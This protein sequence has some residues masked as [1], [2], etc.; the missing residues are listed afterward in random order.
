MASR[1]LTAPTRA[2]LRRSRG[3]PLC[4]D[5]CVGQSAHEKHNGSAN[6]GNPFHGFPL[7]KEARHSGAL[8]KL[9]DPFQTCAGGCDAGLRA[10]LPW[11][12]RRDVF[13][14]HG[15]GWPKTVPSGRCFQI[16]IPLLKAE[17]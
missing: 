15:G 7:G 11:S 5:G 2:W 6:D 8:E 14:D 10:V 16:L 12:L 1:K 3:F 17:P 13:L 9:P 4:S